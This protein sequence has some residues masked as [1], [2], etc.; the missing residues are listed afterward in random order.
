MSRLR[1]YLMMAAIVTAGVCVATLTQGQKVDP[2]VTKSTAALKGSFTDAAQEAELSTV[3]VM[4]QDADRTVPAAYGT[5]MTAD[6]FILTKSSEIINHKMVFVKLAGKEVEAKIVGVRESYDLAMLKVDARNLVPVK[7]ANIAP[8]PAASKP[9]ATPA[10]VGG[11]GRGRGRT[12]LQPTGPIPVVAPAHEAPADA[13]DVNVGEFVITP[14]AGASEDPKLAKSLAPKAYGVI[15]VT[16][17]SIPFSS[18]VLGVGLE[19]YISEGSPAPQGALVTEVFTR[20]GAG[21]AG[22]KPDDIITAV[23]GTPVTSRLGLQNLIRKHYPTDTVTLS[24][25]RGDQALSLRVQLGDT[26]LATPEDVEMAVLS[27]SVNQRSSDFQAVFQHDTIL[28]PTDMGGPLVDLEGHVIG[29]NIARAGRT[30]TYAIPADLLTERWLDSM[31][32]GT[33]APRPRP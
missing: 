24:I 14:E 18:G 8:Q 6:G 32:D 4:V 19:D 29:I 5:V 28:A 22:V 30:E 10:Q 21:R 3:R 26:I 9:T 12:L 7:L 15:S 20:S 27:G 1:S 33:F 25:T 13:V 16:R 31:K 11:A 17:R 23:D 2:W